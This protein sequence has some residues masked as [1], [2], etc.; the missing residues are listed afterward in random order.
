M[1]ICTW[2]LCK[3]KAFILLRVCICMYKCTRSY[4]LEIYIYIWIHKHTHTHQKTHI[5]HT[6][7]RT[8]THTSTRTHT[9]TTPTYTCILTYTLTLTHIRRTF[10]PAKAQSD[11]Q[12]NPASVW[13]SKAKSPPTPR[14]RRAPPP[15]HS[16]PQFPRPQLPPAHCNWPM[17]STDVWNISSMRHQCVSNASSMS[18]QWVYLHIV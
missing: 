8:R 5:T 10:L 16:T 1:Y 9:H 11:A 15:S 13:G 14:P 3:Q 4:V 7:T 18:Q 2:E 12:R 6:R 17:R